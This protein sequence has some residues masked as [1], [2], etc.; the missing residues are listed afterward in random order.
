[1]LAIVHDLASP[2]PRQCK[3][4]V[5]LKRGRWAPKFLGVCL[6]D[7]LVNAPRL[8]LTVGCAALAALVVLAASALVSLPREAGAFAQERSA[9]AAAKQGSAGSTTDEQAVRKASA[10]YLEAMNKGDL[11]ARLAFWAPDAEYVNEAGKVT[12]G[13]E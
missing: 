11:E 10:G 9:P 7:T 5:I 2:L 4:A 3:A 1:M 8:R 6:E 13:R 12:R